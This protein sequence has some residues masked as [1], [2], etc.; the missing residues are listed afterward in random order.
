MNIRAAI[1]KIDELKERV[2]ALTTQNTELRFENLTL[3]MQLQQSIPVSFPKSSD[4]TI[5]MRMADS[6]RLV[7]EL[8]AQLVDA[9]RQI[10]ELQQQGF[11]PNES[12]PN[13][14][15]E[16]ER[17]NHKV[18][19]RERER[20]TSTIPSIMDSHIL[21][22]TIQQQQEYEA[23]LRQ[24]KLQN[25]VT[26]LTVN[27][28]DGPLVTIQT[29]TVEEEQ[30]ELRMSPATVD[31][32]NVNAIICLMTGAFLFKFNRRLTKAERRFVTVNPYIRTISWSKSEPGHAR[33]DE[34]ATV[35]IQAAHVEELSD[36]RSRIVIKAPHREVV[37][38]CN[39]AVE[40][41]IWE[42]GLQLVLQNNDKSQLVPLFESYKRM[43]GNQG[44]H[45]K[46]GTCWWLLKRLML[47]MHSEVTESRNDDF[48]GSSLA[49]SYY[50][51]SIVEIEPFR[52][53]PTFAD[54]L[55]LLE[56]R[57]ASFVSFKEEA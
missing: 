34:V 46:K 37:F 50:S 51:T 47:E 1:S 55:L 57:K 3:Q 40:H 26:D 32:V 14:D 13:S 10:R 39:S 12:L 56:L 42:R 41:A 15:D 25:P 9:K 22:V 28:S 48:C 7:K 43:M 24:R 36:G 21:G 2:E 16:D 31:N 45:L 35:Y 19:Q 18:I 17:L 29:V 23:L 52:N 44:V 20:P 38:Q 33:A 8:H 49:K 27:E 6:E 54:V 4:A 5:E 11:Q 53:M 30:M